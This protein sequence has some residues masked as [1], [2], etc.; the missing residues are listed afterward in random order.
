M[1]CAAAAM[2]AL[3][4]STIPA[5]D[6]YFIIQSAPATLMRRE[7]RQREIL[8]DLSKYPSTMVF[9]SA[10]SLHEE[11]FKDLNATLAPDTP[12]AVVFWAGYPD[13]ERILH[14]TVADMS[15]K[16][17][18]EKETFMGLVLV[19]RFLE[20]KPRTAVMERAHKRLLEKAIHSDKR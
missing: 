1:G 19:G 18:K 6:N 11:L 17:S 5:H 10:L 4:R 9:Y 14:G 12:C 2:A 15:E 13:K 7:G 3:K 16:L 8:K 20:G